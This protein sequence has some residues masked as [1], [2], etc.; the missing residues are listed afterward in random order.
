V[1][2]KTLLLAAHGS[3]QHD[4][5]NPILRLAETLHEQKIFNEVLCGFLRQQPF[6]RNVLSQIQ[7]TELSVIPMFSGFGYITD[8][9]I[10]KALGQVSN[11]ITVHLYDPIGV[12]P[13]IPMIMAK[14]A[15]SIIKEHGLH[16]AEV[17]VLVVAHGHTKNFQNAD[18]TNAMAA[19]LKKIMNGIT[20][21]TAFI[22]EAPLIS[23]WPKFTTAE[24]LIVLPYMIGGGLHTQEDVPIMLGLNSG[25]YDKT[26]VTGPL[27][28]HGKTIWYCRA[29][30]FEEALSD[31]IV[32]IVSE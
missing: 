19:D 5:N 16:P 30:G 22:E 10:P 2:N 23:D 18:Q 32:G 12:H 26:P 6:L 7:A 4:G 31:I 15:S 28:A 17:T 27:S 11:E 3:S 9:L 1:S 24:H 14:R 25:N 20:T 21:S 29:F 8:T 13:N